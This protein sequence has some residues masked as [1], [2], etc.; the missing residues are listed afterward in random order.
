MALP[1]QRVPVLGKTEH[2]HE[3]EGIDV[4][5]G[6]LPNTDPYHAWGLFELVQR[7]QGRL[8]EIDLLVLAPTGLF[9]VEIKSRPGVYTGDHQDWYVDSPDRDRPT[10]LENPFRLTNHKAKV[11]GSIL[12]H[13]LH[14]APWVQPLV[15]LSA[16]NVELKLQPQGELGVVTRKGFARAIT[17]HEFPGA[18]KDDI[19]FPVNRPMMREVLQAIKDLGI[20][21]SQ[22]ELHVGSYELVELLDDG[23]IYQEWSARHR[24]ARSVRGRARVY[25]EPEQADVEQRRSL[26]RAAEREV[27]LLQ[28]VRE[29][30]SILRFQAYVEDGRLGPT[31][32]YDAFEGGELLDAFVRKHPELPFASR[33]AILRDVGYALQH[34]HSK[35]V[36]HGNVHPR[37][38]LVRLDEQGSPDVRLF[39]FQLGRREQV[40]GTQHRSVLQGDASKLYQAPELF[41]DPSASSIATDV[42]SLGALAYFVLTGLDPAP[43]PI[44]LQRLLAERHGLQPQLASEA[45]PDG[46]GTVVESATQY[47]AA[48]RPETVGGWLNDLLEAAT[49]PEVTPSEEISPYAAQRESL[50]CGGRFLVERVLGRGA[51]SHVLQVIDSRNDNRS[52]ALKVSLGE[53]HDARLDAEADALR[54]P[55]DRR[56]VQLVERLTL[57]GRTALLLSLAGSKTLQALL[58]EEGP[59]SLDFACRYG[60]DLLDSLAHLEELGIPHRDVKPANLGVGSTN[61]RRANHLILFDFSLVGAALEDIDVG[62]AVYR[63]PF[64]VQR[65]RWDSAGDRWSAAITL[66]EMLTGERPQF[67]GPPLEPSS[68]LVLA[69]ERF[70]MARE[71]LVAFFQRALARR[72]G[73]R[74]Q[75]AEAMKRAWSTCFVERARPPAAAEDAAVEP[76]S[77]ERATGPAPIDYAAIGLDTPIAQLPLSARARNGLERAGLLRAEDL[78]SLP[79]NHLSAV[80]GVSRG[81][82]Q[83][84]LSFRDQWQQAQRLQSREA[85]PFFDAYSG[86]NLLLSRCEGVPAAL[87]A[88]LADA[89]LKTLAQIAAAPSPRV[90]ALCHAAQVNSKALTELLRGEARRAREA[91]LPS[92]LES[93]VAVLVGGKSK[94]LGYV[95]ALYGLEAPFEGQ[96]EA[97]G[98]EVGTHFGVNPVNVYVAVAKQRA[99][100]RQL[101]ARPAL[102]E[103][104]APVLDE[105]GGILP[106]AEGARQ[107][108]T[109]LPHAASTSAALLLAQA[110]ALLR[111]ASELD[112][113]ECPL[114]VERLSR[115]QLWVSRSDALTETVRRLGAAADELAGREM[116]ASPVEALRVLGAACEPPAAEGEGG[117]PS[118]VRLATGGPGDAIGRSPLAQLPAERLV[119]LAAEASQG[120]AASAHLEIY[121]RAMSAHRALQHSA[122]ILTG[123]LSPEDVQRRVSGRYP[124]ASPL[125][126]RPALDR[127]LERL[128][129]TWN[130]RG[131]ARRSAS[132]S[133][134]FLTDGT[135]LSE[136]RVPFSPDE[137]AAAAFRAQLQSTLEQREVRVLSVRSR[138]QRAAAQKLAAEFGLEI[139]SLDHELHTEMKELASREGVALE[140]VYATDGQGPA[141]PHWPLLKELAT[142]A[143]KQ[144]ATRRLPPEQPVLFTQMGLVARYAL[145]PLLEQIT[146]SVRAERAAVLILVAGNASTGFTL[147][148]AL[149]V[150]GVLPAQ[151]T[152]VSLAWL[153]AERASETRS[154]PPLRLR[155]TGSE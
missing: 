41:H 69:A 77:S 20:R 5:L 74:F 135:R 122:A 90:A 53:R 59:V 87:P 91:Q 46:V 52:F 62:T 138:Y 102:L 17:H 58:T 145:S 73:D 23:D 131:F 107:L 43:D 61:G 63:D 35:Q 3:K 82:A 39:R 128:D 150:P 66:H 37:A 146:A 4:A 125:P 70:E 143:A 149:T 31:V 148:G 7:E 116:L 44:A 21:E 36:L 6:A 120:A 29:H 155:R 140:T 136:H 42:F 15:F 113:V 152:P 56:I 142:Q 96:L 65:G 103:L 111:V 13:R 101:E 76:E 50:L 127:L 16:Q 55:K 97:T 121:P 38:V 67:S 9:L 154:K 132:L 51:T 88:V 110:A 147:N 84:I 108:L 54:K 134:T 48:Y 151:C 19:R 100:W 137:L 129:L 112:D 57:A 92:S 40:T 83:A 45:I 104:C 124:E 14:R 75:S 2:A 123:E 32:I 64:L 49:S 106:L 72:A 12:R 71:Q 27:D 93:W 47:I 11:L 133:S 80:R 109:T 68:P 24:A 85:P 115:K 98:V 114:S 26:R 78:L 118:E 95:R 10:F 139:A 81:V 30:P 86:A 99:R 28:D 60:E 117:S 8:Y 18:R 130:G 141:G 126:P 144:L 34:C 105:A 1:R 153:R 79:A 22:G 33:I 94:A 25:L 89:G 119:P